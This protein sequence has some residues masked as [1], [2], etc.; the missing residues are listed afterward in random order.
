MVVG[1]WGMNAIIAAGQNSKE[2][3]REA[4][5]L[6][7]QDAIEKHIYTHTG[8]RHIGDKDVYL[9]QGGAIGADGINV[10]LDPQLSRYFLPSPIETDITE[11][12]KERINFIFIGKMSITLPLWACMYLAPLAE[13]IEPSFTLWVVG[14]SGTYKS[15]STG[16]ALCQFGDLDHHHLPASWSS[17]YNLLE[18]LL[19]FIKDAPIVIDDWAPGQNSQK[20]TQLEEK[21]EHI[22][23][24]QGNRQGKARM[25]SD[26]SSRPVY[27]P[28][29]MLITSGEQLP[30]GHSHTA[31][32]YAV[33]IEPGDIDIERLSE[34]QKRR[35]LYRQAMAHYIKSLQTNWQDKKLE[36]RAEFDKMR[37]EY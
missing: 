1:K 13:A 36:L 15:V 14:P 4:M 21:A 23:R 5:Q 25:S 22:I 17:T 33:H 19:F 12:V 3:L 6:M 8:W 31:R 9:C 35:H 32:I 34:A 29:G 27:V 18:K 10:E 20:Q 7:S 2:R 16:L 26:T 24:D 37:A 30:S 28:R 11:A